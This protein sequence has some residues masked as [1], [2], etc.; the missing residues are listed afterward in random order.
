MSHNFCVLFGHRI[1]TGFVPVILACCIFT[2]I[3]AITYK[4]QIIHGDDD[5]SNRNSENFMSSRTRDYWANDYKGRGCSAGMTER[6]V[7]SVELFRSQLRLIN[8]SVGTPPQEFTVILDLFW[9]TDLGLID[10]GINTTEEYVLQKHLFNTSN[11][12]TFV[13]S[14]RNITTDYNGVNVT[15]GY[16]GS[17]ILQLGGDYFK[18]SFNL[19]NT[20]DDGFVYQSRDGTLGLSIFQ[21]SYNNIS[22]MTQIMQQLDRPI[23]SMWYNRSLSFR[24]DNGASRPVNIKVNKT[25]NVDMQ[26]VAR[27]GYMPYYLKFF[28]VTAANATWDRDRYRY[29]ADCDLNKAKSVI[30]NIGGNGGVV[31]MS[32]RKVVVTPAEYIM[33]SE[34]SNECFV[35]IDGY[36]DDFGETIIR[37]PLQFYNRHCYSYNME[38]DMIGIATAVDNVA[39]FPK[40]DSDSTLVFLEV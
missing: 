23:F 2:A 8:I 26:R 17:D 11:S 12:T 3:E 37:M 14:D 29:F 16:V 38:T 6:S 7:E 24:K 34:D 22:A 13:L 19:V 18:L 39:T 32:S 5:H 10:S 31:D 27:R 33:Q 35:S 1:S 30:L 40:V 25:L 9:Q 21:E 20:T 4:V 15:T 36:N 28:F